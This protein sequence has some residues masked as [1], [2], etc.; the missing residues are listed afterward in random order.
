MKPDKLLTKR[1]HGSIIISQIQDKRVGRVS[2]LKFTDVRILTG[3]CAF[4]VDDGKTAILYDTGFGFTGEGIAGKIRAAL[5][6]RQLDYIFLTHSHYD[7]V[8]GAPHIL[9]RYPDAKVVAGEYVKTIFAKASAREKMREL[10]RKFAHTCGIEAYD[11]L[12][13]TLRVD[14]AVKDG[15]V[16]TC[17]DMQFTV[18][19][20]PG[21]TKCSVGFY[22]EDEELL[23]S[24]ETL[25]V[26]FG[27]DTYMPSYL[28]GYQMT[29]D[30]FEKAK[31]LNISRILA[32]HYGLIEGDEAKRFLDN[33]QR[34]SRAFAQ[35]LRDIFASGGSDE[36]ALDYC[37]DH[38]YLEHVRPTY[39]IDAF[40]LNSSIMIDLIRKETV[41]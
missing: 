25:G 15:D 21:H 7:H 1:G 29:M 10:D 33:S 17:G 19:E 32:P 18:V 12:V 37:R 26:Y 2:K 22:L 41:I 3:D 13:D 38:I 11:D 8:L 4:L 9:K 30:S 6:N 20:L 28:V 36:D 5:G 35:A 16:I 34:A 40:L 14:I 27:N 24:T 39:P 31:K 23:L